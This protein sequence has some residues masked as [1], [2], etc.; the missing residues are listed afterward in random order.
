MVAYRLLQFISLWVLIFFRETNS[1][2][3]KVEIYR[4]IAKRGR[5]ILIG[6]RSMIF[7][8]RLYSYPNILEQE[9][10]PEGR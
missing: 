9:R 1:R 3:L 8:N 7:K 10:R 2:G 5:F 6:R 4:C